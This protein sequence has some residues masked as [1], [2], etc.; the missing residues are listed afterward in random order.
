M[1]M[2]KDTAFH[3]ALAVAALAAAV[4]LIHVGINWLFHLILLPLAR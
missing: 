3:A 2:A 1:P 4:A